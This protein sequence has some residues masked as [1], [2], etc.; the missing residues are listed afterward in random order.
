MKRLSFL[1]KIVKEGK[2]KL[3]D[4]SQDVSESYLLKSQNCIKSSK[5][6]LDADLFENSVAEAYYA[7]YNAALSLLF[8]CGIKCENHTATIILMEDVFGLADLGKILAKAKKERIDKQYYVTDDFID[9]EAAKSMMTDAENFTLKLRVFSGKLNQ[10]SISAL[11][12][13]FS[14]NVN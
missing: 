12:Q 9:E 6:L 3:V 10:Q 2:L 14:K 13:K 11:R 8:R 1:S 5:I 4:P 7:M